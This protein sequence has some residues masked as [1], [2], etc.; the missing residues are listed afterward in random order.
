[1]SMHSVKKP[2]KLKKKRDSLKSNLKQNNKIDLIEIINSSKL[3]SLRAHSY[4][5]EQSVLV[6]VRNQ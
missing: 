4:Y 2:S 6:R 5:P 3:T 1:M